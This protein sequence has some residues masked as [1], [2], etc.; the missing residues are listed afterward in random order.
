[1]NILNVLAMERSKEV[2][3]SP[4]EKQAIIG[5]HLGKLRSSTGLNKRSSIAKSSIILSNKGI[6]I[7]P[8]ALIDEIELANEKIQ[9]ENSILTKDKKYIIPKD[10]SVKYGFDIAMGFFIIYSVITSLFYLAFQT[11]QNLAKGFDVFVWVIFLTDFVLMFF[12]EIRDQKDQ[13]IMNFK[14]IALD[15][16]Q[17]WMI[18]DILSLIPCAMFGNPNTEYFLRLF[19]VLKMGR[20]F[21][22]LDI[23]VLANKIINYFYEQESVEKVKKKMMIIYGW[24]MLLQVLKMIFATYFL[25]CIWY[26]YIDLVIRKADEPNDFKMN[27]NL[28][29][30]KPYKRF[31]KTWY[32]IFTTL[33]TVGYGDFYATN[34]YEMGLA[35]LILL[36]GPTW[37][38]FTMGNAIQI[39]NELASLTSD[40]VSKNDF[41]IWISN[42]TNDKGAI[43]KELKINIIDHF[44]YYWRRDRLA[45]IANFSREDNFS[46]DC[47]DTFFSEIPQKIKKEIF[48]YLFSDI[49][50][51]FK[52]FF[53]YFYKARFEITR[54]FQPRH[55]LLN[56]IILDGDEKVNEILFITEGTINA[57]LLS[58]SD[59]IPFWTHKGTFVLGDYFYLTNSKPFSSFIAVN[60]V[61]GFAIS[62]YGLSE[63]IKIYRI[64]VS[65]YIK[66]IEP[67]YANL[68][69]LYR[70]V[71][72]DT[73]EDQRKNSEKNGLLSS[74]TKKLFSGFLRNSL[75][76]SYIPLD[77][78]DKNK[79][80][81]NDTID[82]VAHYI[83]KINFNRKTLLWE[84]KEKMAWNLKCRQETTVN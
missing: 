44:S 71:V 20:L 13:K 75:L 22:F 77:D 48:Q 64:D 29:L 25:A 4:A 30:D 40:S 54:L 26:Y 63:I 28:M 76:S 2:Q 69:T 19:R 31:I 50:H 32:Y 1:M 65:Q 84:L 80:E 17:K 27:F 72:Q 7:I 74:S 53:R 9:E 73:Q 11:D 70:G 52:F 12:T 51:N 41:N 37:F 46:L 59:K 42:I 55:F 3:H 6:G 45:N 21:M 15:Y 56:K 83:D 62:T 81:F 34:T 49:Y 38:A 35:I 82:R 16:L 18:F 33:V 78:N 67:F 68:D 47:T 5:A 36:A 57:T 60:H 66:Y 79:R 61:H 8:N 10:N 23:Y 14:L 39:I 58:N 24:Q 43:P